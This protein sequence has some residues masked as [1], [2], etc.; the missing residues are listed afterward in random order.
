MKGVFVLDKPRGPTSRQCDVWFSGIT[1]WKAGHAG[2]L[3]PKVSGV[4]PILFGK[5]TKLMP[6]FQKADKEY[7]AA[8]KVHGTF[9]PSVLDE[10]VGEIEQLPPKRS[11]VRRRFRKRRVY[12]IEVI[13]RMDPVVLLRFHVESGTYIRKLI[14]DIGERIGGAHMI[15]LRRTRAGP[16]GEDMAFTFHDLVDELEF[17][18][19]GV[20]ERPEVFITVEKALE[21]AG[22]ARIWIRSREKVVKGSPVFVGNVE[23]AEDFRKG[24]WVAIYHGTECVALGRAVEEMARAERIVAVPDAVL[25]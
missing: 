11:A 24:D 12:S 14:H 8:M 22:V 16:F 7:V 23:R 15:E 6:V 3:D 20:K 19:R 21:M 2:T 4:L 10:F 5:A 17:V 9:D 25:V 18:R 13:D 1:G